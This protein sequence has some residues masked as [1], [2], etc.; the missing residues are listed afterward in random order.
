MPSAIT[1]LSRT[2]RRRYQRPG[3]SHAVHIT[4]RI[5]LRPFP[6]GPDATS[7]EVYGPPR[8]LHPLFFLCPFTQP[9]RRFVSASFGLTAFCELRPNGFLRTSA[10]RIGIFAGS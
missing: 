5:T 1:P 2:A 3:S 7:G 8:R 4:S 9:R 10:V 6:L